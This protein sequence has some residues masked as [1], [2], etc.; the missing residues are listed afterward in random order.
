M[1][2]TLVRARCADCG[3]VVFPLSGLTVLM[4]DSGSSYVAYRC[5]DCGRRSTQPVP[6][7]VTTTLSRV[8]VAVLPLTRPA[9]VDE[10]HAGPTIT[11][12]DVTAFVGAFSRPD[13]QA[14]LSV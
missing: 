9:E 11:D 5:P 12:D 13:W 3:E 10:P 6:L 2:E 8:G 7:A 14:E 1:S 4:L